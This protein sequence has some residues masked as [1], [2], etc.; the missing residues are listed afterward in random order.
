MPCVSS[1]SENGVRRTSCPAMPQRKAMGR[2]VGCEREGEEGER[3]AV[4][5]PLPFRQ[6]R[7]APAFES[8]T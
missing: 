2:R 6:R 5:G 3:G 4:W 8:A 1:Q 7:D